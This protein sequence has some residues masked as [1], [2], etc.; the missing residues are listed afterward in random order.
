MDLTVGGE[1]LLTMH[2]PDGK[3]YYNRSVFR[4]LVSQRKI[5]FEHFS[6]NFI[7][8]ILFQEIGGNTIMEWIMTFETAA[9]YEA[10]VQTY[11]ADEGLEQNIEKLEKYLTQKMNRNE[12]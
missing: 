2:G 11:K 5:V 8:T 9:L 3:G 4:E 1:W 6:P 10:V 12:K 7:A